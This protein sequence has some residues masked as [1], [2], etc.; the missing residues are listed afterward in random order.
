M[1]ASCLDTVRLNLDLKVD[2]IARDVPISAQVETDEDRE[3]VRRVKAGDVLAFR[4]LVERYQKR[5]H[6]I[7]MGI[8]GSYADAEDVVQDAFLKAYRNISFFR[9]ESSFYTW[10][11]RIVYNLAIDYGR[12]KYRHVESSVGDSVMLDTSL[13][14]A[15]KASSPAV[16]R[17]ENPDESLT[18]RELGEE[19]SKAIAELSPDHRAVIVLREIEGLSYS[20]ISDLIGCSKGTVMSRLHHARKKLQKSL[21]R[22][23]SSENENFENNSGPLLVAKK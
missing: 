19:I 16:G 10:L 7:A 12:K 9:E 2:S 6:A 18:R 1:G 20:E 23:L 15:Q 4:E 22:F 17:A 11:Y 14:K 13:Q 5:A 8:V 21:G 3:L